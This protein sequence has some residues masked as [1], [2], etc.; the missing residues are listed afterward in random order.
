MSSK[1][2][3]DSTLLVQGLAGHAKKASQ[4][5]ADSTSAPGNPPVQTVPSDSG[6]SGTA[7]FEKCEC[8]GKPRHQGQ[9]GGNV[10]SEDDWFGLEEGV[11]LYAERAKLDSEIKA[12]IAKLPEDTKISM[13]ERNIDV[14]EAVPGPLKR[15]SQN[16]KDSIRRF[17]MRRDAVEFSRK[18]KCGSIP[19]LPCDVYRVV[20]PQQ[21]KQLEAEWDA[22]RAG[23]QSDNGL[24]VS[25]KIRHRV[26]LEAGGCPTGKGN[27]VAE[28]TLSEVCLPA[29]RKLITAQDDAAVR[30]Q[31]GGFD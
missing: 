7:V 15:R 31:N 1:S 20:A 29:I 23:F 13:A 22:E 26:P 10:V 18:N 21:S 14:M 28:S 6:P 11:E 19:G 2:P 12:F 27:L 30:W 4:A 5:V 24:A 3:Q 25:E 17:E 8:C 16:N 9:E